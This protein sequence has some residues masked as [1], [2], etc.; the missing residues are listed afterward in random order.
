MLKRL[1]LILLLGWGT[2]HLFA[3]TEFEE[4]E[5]YEVV[6]VPFDADPDG[7][8][9]VVTEVFSYSCNH[10]YDFEE[11]LGKWLAQQDPNKVKFERIHVVFAR[12]M[13]NL[14]RAYVA[15]ELLGVTESTHE[16]I[17][18]AIHKNGL[19]MNREDLLQRLFKNKANIEV[20]DFK[21]L[22]DS[23]QITQRLSETQ[24]K[25]RVWR[26][27]ATPTMVVDGRY[28]T[29]PTQATS[30]RKVLEIVDFLVDKAIQDRGNE[31]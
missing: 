22:F 7:L 26:I 10:C 17:F 14:A 12:D 29:T 11:P 19:R 27:I 6:P 28:T 24:G 23:S 16:P 20:D 1:I 4:G 21:Q 3:Q 2:S 30:K 25:A 15:S 18:S 5:H 8:P 9:I 31:S 13:I